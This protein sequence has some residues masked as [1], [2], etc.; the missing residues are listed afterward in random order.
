MLTKRLRNVMDFLVDPCQAAFVS[1]RMLNDNVILS[2]ELVKGYGRKGIS[3]RCMFKVDM[4]KAYDSIEWHFLEK[5]LK[6]MQ[7]PA[8]FI[9]WIMQCVKTVTYSI[10]I[11]GTPSPAFKAKRGVR[12]GG[13]L[14]PYL[15][16][17]A[18]DY[19]TRLLKTLRAKKEFKFHLR[20]QK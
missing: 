7:F 18:M 10:Q 13:P 12:Q 6:G 17:L 16:V 8:S 14:S 3:P 19:L 4:Q 5:V 11:N 15:F 9:T 1:G 20:Y 2:H